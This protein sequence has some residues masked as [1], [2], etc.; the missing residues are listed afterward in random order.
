MEH[1][2]RPGRHSLPPEVG[3]TLTR[4]ARVT[5]ELS[6]ATTVDEVTKIVTQQMADAVGATIATLALREGEDAVRLLGTRGLDLPEAEHWRVFPLSVPNTITEVI[7]SGRRLVLVGAEVIAA[8]YPDLDIPSRGERTTVTVPLRVAGRTI[9]A[10]HLSLPGAEDP[11]DAELEFLDV[12]ADACAQAFVRIESSAVA[13]R[14]TARLAFLAEASIQLAS[15]L[16][17]EVTTNRVARLAVPSFADWCAIDVV[18]DGTL[19]RLAVAHVDPEKV[20]LAWELHRRWPPDP[21]RRDGV[22]EVVRTGRPVLMS[23]ITDEVIDTV[24]NDPEQ[25]RVMRELGL[26]SALLVPLLVRGRVSGVLTWVSTDEDRT[27]RED[28]VRFAEHLARR[29]A[30]AIDNAD[31]FSQTRDVAV[32]LQRAVLPGR[33]R[34]TEE[35]EVHCLYEPSGRTEVG[36]DFYDA[37]PLA[38]G[39]FVA[40]VGDVMGRGVA[41]AAAMAQMRSAVRAFVSADPSPEAVVDCLDTMVRQYET[42]QL[43]TLTVVVAEPRTGELRLVNAGHLPGLVLRADGGHEFLPWADGPPLGLATGRRGSTVHLGV[44]DTLL[45]VTDGVVERRDE[46]ITDGLDRLVGALGSLAGADLEDGLRRL[47]H[48]VGDEGSDDDR[49]ALV[50]RRSS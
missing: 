46:D 37:F 23:S 30:S 1:R 17:L 29:S 33:V 39:R 43:V 13:E 7:R 10:I 9:G 2:D 31:L 4:L 8:R 6:R 25:R 50:L 47:V 35:W 27:Y 45:V 18:R 15:S 41:A 48:E 44:G 40:F 38:D 34:G 24:V 22:M 42:D 32:Q 3:D 28:D 11:P 14:Q 26:R 16:D 21:S 36:G 20:E 19:R 5:A 49:A 12:L